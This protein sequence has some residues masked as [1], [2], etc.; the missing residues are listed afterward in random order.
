[1]GL[2]ATMVAS[3]VTG[4][5]PARA[6]DASIGSIPATSPE[7]DDALIV[8]VGAEGS[9]EFEGTFDRWADQWATLS[10]KQQWQLRRIGGASGMP[11]DL[12]P[13]EQLQKCIAEFSKARRLWIVMLGHGTFARNIAKFNLTGPDISSQ[14]MKS[15]LMPVTAQTIV[16]SCF[17]SAAPFL[18]DLNGDNRILITATKSGSEYNFSR[19]GEYLANS[20]NDPSI[21]IDHDNEVSLLEAF[22]AATNLVER[23]YREESRL[24]TEHA[25]L[26]D[27]GDK[28]GTTADFYRGVR[29]AKAGQGG[30]IDGAA[31]SRIILLTSPDAATFPPELDEKR[32]AI[33]QQIDRLRS[34]KS[35][36]S[37]D[38]YY[39]Q[40]EI[41]LLQ[42]ALLYDA[43]EESASKSRV[44]T[45]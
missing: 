4:A 24:A 31:A 26:N 16:I 40:L 13:K 6:Q 36:L 2:L 1:M 44:L 18:T 33:E 9:P 32:V 30:Q 5:A 19:F 15:W 11:S 42:L 29:P 45:N 39:A 41:L 43:A 27:N 21:D 17:S 12:F 38:D 3:I 23:F 7:I 10:E 35:L 37:S 22:L 20:I 34:Q 14:E 28:V 25:L 8:V